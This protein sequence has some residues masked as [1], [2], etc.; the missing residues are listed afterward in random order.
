[1]LRGDLER[2]HGK[3]HEGLLSALALF[4]PR[5]AIGGGLLLM[6][7]K[8]KV[9]AAAA[10]LVLIAGLA[11]QVLRG[12]PALESP[13]P[14]RSSAVSAEQATELPAGAP[15]ARLPVDP[16]AAPSSAADCGLRVEVVDGR[17]GAALAGV[18]VIIQALS[19][20]GV[21]GEWVDSSDA[22]GFVVKRGLGAG[23]HY[24]SCDR[25]A[26]AERIELQAGL[27][28]TV[29]LTV[30]EG[31]SVHG[32]VVDLQ[33]HGV[34]GAGICISWG[35]TNNGHIAL[36]AD[37]NADFRIADLAPGQL[38]GAR[39]PGYAPSLQRQVDGRPG[40][41]IEIVLILQ[42]VGGAWTGHV[43]DPE[44]KPV[45]GARIV[46]RGSRG[47]QRFP[48]PDGR[49]GS[50][51]GSLS[52]LSDSD[53]AFRFDGLAPG[54][55][56][57]SAQAHGFVHWMDTLAISEGTAAVLDVHLGPGA[58]LH[59]RLLDPGGLPVAGAKVQFSNPPEFHTIYSDEQGRFAKSGIAAGKYHFTVD[60]GGKGHAWSRLALRVGEDKE[61]N[62]TLDPGNVYAGRLVD[63]TGTALVGWYATL[64]QTDNIIYG[65]EVDGEYREDWLD[66]WGW[67][68]TDQ[69]GRFR[70]SNLPAG[71]PFRIEVRL[72]RQPGTKPLVVLDD[73]KPNGPEVTIVVKAADLELSQV[74]G[75]LVDQ[76]G[77][78]LE[79]AGVT[80]DEIPVRTGPG[81]PGSRL[82]KGNG[83]F[84]IRNVPHGRWRLNVHAPG[85][86]CDPQNLEVSSAEPVELGQIQMR[87]ISTALT[88]VLT[89]A[90]GGPFGSPSVQLFDLR[91]DPQTSLVL[92]GNRASSRTIA[93]GTYLLR[94]LD[95]GKYL[96]SREI[97]LPEGEETKL[98]IELPA[99][100]K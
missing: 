3:G 55:A 83:R 36:H 26:E 92:E 58:T 67:T 47:D 43:F 33:G 60:A 4:A 6:A 75:T 11:W 15:E 31:V 71:M 9:A 51:P 56:N 39:M 37:H 28:K 98:E 49:M 59:G 54:V 45:A 88:V 76:R 74:S 38:V 97:T 20:S 82:E 22:D 69:E 25:N 79:D 91:G 41:D 99:L 17:S 2:R 14:P 81:G 64:L 72:P 13:P 48:L 73:Q 46:A 93:G 77:A 5:E 86:T 1:M 87:K 7:H 78:P 29:R 100:P 89:R 8:T 34:P 66:S 44:G 94:V 95:Q 10:L 61:W 80:L 63:E 50:H 23:V 68:K 70:A 96:P 85:Y 18:G 12:G 16:A 30:R 24:V 53:G 21:E 90:G 57:V 62:A 19:R 42:G 84:T 32:K 52:T 40:D 65:R 35:L 27:V